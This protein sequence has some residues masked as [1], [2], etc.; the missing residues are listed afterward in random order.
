MN[1]IIVAEIRFEIA[2][3]ATIIRGNDEVT[4]VIRYRFCIITMSGT[5]L[6][7]LLRS[8]VNALIHIT[9]FRSIIVFTSNMAIQ[10]M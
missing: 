7:I 6:D 5:C 8:Q 1:F 9:N 10:C 4:G 2:Y 3:F